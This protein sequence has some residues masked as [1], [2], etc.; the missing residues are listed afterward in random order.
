MKQLCALVLIIS[1]LAAKAQSL[2]DIMHQYD[3]LQLSGEKFTRT[4]AYRYHTVTFYISYTAFQKKLEGTMSRQLYYYNPAYTVALQ[5]MNK[6]GYDTVHL[7]Q[8]L[9]DSAGIIPFDRF[10]AEQLETGACKLA[11][12]SGTLVPYII[13]D[14]FIQPHPG[15]WTGRRFLLP[16]NTDYFLLVTDLAA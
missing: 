7:S 4:V 2:P 9:F 10:L 6:Q 12:E 3:T 5:H 8:S 1:S 11:D 13:K 14:K 16:G 15:L